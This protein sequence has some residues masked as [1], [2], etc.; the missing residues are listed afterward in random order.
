MT[1]PE[2]VRAIQQDRVRTADRARLARLAACIQACCSPSI[3][4][5]FMRA[6]RPAPAGS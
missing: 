5:R 6:V 4:S 1:S 2:L 3:I